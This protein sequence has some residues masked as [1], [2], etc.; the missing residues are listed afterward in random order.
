MP[1]P[2][3]DLSL[4]ILGPGRAGRALARSWIAAGGRPPV[5]LARTAESAR[6]AATGLPGSDPRTVDGLVGESACDVLVLAVPDDRIAVAAREI[7]RRVSCRVAIHLSGFLPA[8]ALSPLADAGAAVAS[9]HPLR[10][11]AGTSSEDWNGAFVAVEGDPAAVDAAIGIA[12]ALGARPHRLPAG[13]RPLYHAGATLAAGGVVA[14]LSMAARAWAAGGL[15]GPETRQAL[16]GLTLDAVRAARDHDFA[17]AFTGAVARRDLGTIRAHRDALAALPDV[18]RIYAALA[19]ET[20]Q[21]TPGRGGEAEIRRM[22]SV[23]E[24]SRR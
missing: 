24:P 23:P 1:A 3:L 10:A 22:L 5:L 6:D 12:S 7:A 8:S 19:E 21:R 2:P 20:L 17:E 18:L 9:V 15:S 13:A 16:A 4:W 14:L 11:F